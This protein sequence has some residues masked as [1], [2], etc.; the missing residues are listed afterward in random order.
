MNR[1]ASLADLVDI[2]NRLLAPDGCPWDR[3]QT[4]ASLRPYLVE[5]TF[6]VLEAMEVG[7]PAEH[8]EELGDLLMQVVFQSALRERAGEFNVDDAVRSI[9]DKLVRRHPHVFGQAEVGSAAEVEVQWEEIKRRE[10]A[11][12]GAA[13]GA[14][15][16]GAEEAA[17]QRTLAGVPLGL[18]ALVRANLI[19]ARAARVKFD[20]HD[21][22]G[23]RAKVAEELD[24]IDRAV[25]SGDRAAIEHEIGDLLFAAVSLARKLGVDPEAALRACTRRFTARFEYIEDRLRERGRTPAES[26]LAEMDAL[27][28]Q[29]KAETVASGSGPQKA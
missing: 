14:G 8:C 2:M 5:E 24:E 6:E 23:C 9:C 17:P 4:L 29:A 10:K 22:A 19:S 26:D 3:E 7:T 1:G 25:A 21:A 11:A 16:E 12:A 15:A 20:W 18:P 27:W 28:D 13:K